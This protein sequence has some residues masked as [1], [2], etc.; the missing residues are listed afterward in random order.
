MV[1]IFWLDSGNL[2]AVAF[3]PNLLSIFNPLTDTSKYIVMFKGSLWQR[4]GENQKM[5]EGAPQ[6]SPWGTP[7]N[8][9]QV[10]LKLW[11][12]FILR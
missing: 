2:L 3:S 1:P 8:S 11:C 7:L 4:A 10:D 9:R 5:A 12:T 6:C